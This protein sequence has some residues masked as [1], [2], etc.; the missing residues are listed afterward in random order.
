MDILLVAGVTGTR[1]GAVRPVDTITTMPRR[2]KAVATDP[3]R[4]H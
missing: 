1:D 2:A 4:C 3:D